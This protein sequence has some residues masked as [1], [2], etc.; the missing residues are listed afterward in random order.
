[1]NIFLCTEYKYHT[2]IFKQRDIASLIKHKSKQNL[3]Q[4]DKK[5]PLSNQLSKPMFTFNT[6]VTRESISPNKDE[7]VPF[8]KTS[9]SNRILSPYSPPT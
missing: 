5:N 3:N 8:P 7:T 9:L 1:M 4:I 2:N 6:E